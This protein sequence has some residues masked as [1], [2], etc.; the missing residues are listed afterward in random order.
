MKFEEEDDDDEWVTLV[1]CNFFYSSSSNAYVIVGF[2][3]DM[4]K[5]RVNNENVDIIFVKLLLSLKYFDISNQ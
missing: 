5:S 1:F 3:G 2:I 4:P